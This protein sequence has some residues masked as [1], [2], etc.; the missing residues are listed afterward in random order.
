M[1]QYI[2]LSLILII[3]NPIDAK[4][5]KPS[6]T[7]TIQLHS[8][9]NEHEAALI[10]VKNKNGEKLDELKQITCGKD[11]KKLTFPTKPGEKYYITRVQFKGN[12]NA[13]EVNPNSKAKGIGPIKAGTYEICSEKT[14]KTCNGDVLEKEWPELRLKAINS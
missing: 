10:E 8:H 9:C 3:S 6:E 1:K 5:E 2:L 4:N 13:R 11:G 14:H 12:L 7:L